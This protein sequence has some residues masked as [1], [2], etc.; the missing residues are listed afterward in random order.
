MARL[1]H[2]D[3]YSCFRSRHLL[4]RRD[5]LRGG[6]TIEQCVDGKDKQAVR[7]SKKHAECNA[8]NEPR[9]VRFQVWDPKGPDFF[10]FLHPYVLNNDYGIDDS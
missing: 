6:Q 10:E 2:A 1:L 4:N 8:Q 9:S 7:K 3:I 5:G